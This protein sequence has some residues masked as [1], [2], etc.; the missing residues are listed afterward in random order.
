MADG[1]AGATAASDRQQAIQAL[2]AQLAALPKGTRPYDHARVAYRLGLAYAESP[3]GGP[4]DGLRK[5]LACFDVAAAIFDPRF[6]PIEHARVLNAAGACHRGLGDRGRAATLF[7]KAAELLENSDRDDERAA[8]LNNLGLARAEAGDPAGAVEAFDR[9]VELFDRQ[10]PEGRRGLAATL[11][12][13]GQARGLPG[14][15]E[16][17]QESLGDYQEALAVLGDEEA[18]Y[19]VGLVHHSIGVAYSSLAQARPAEREQALARAMAA[20]EES[21]IVF[22][23]T[24]FP[25]QHALAKH[26][27]GLARAALGGTDNL[28]RALAAFEDAVAILDPR[29]HA[30]PWKQAYASLERTEDHLATSFPGMGRS[31][32]FAALAAAGDEEERVRLVHERLRRLLA[33]PEPRRHAALV[34]LALA[35]ARLPRPSAVKLMTTELSVAMEFPLD[36]QEPVLQA[37]FDAHQQ[38][39]AEAR[40][41]ADRALDEAIGEAL[42]G[43]QRIFVRDFLTGR[44]WERP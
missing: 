12:N 43:P 25:F 39:D 3:L 28:R 23:R 17:V 5:A 30:D 1:P 27:L 6:D 22:T 31:A 18:P 32:H 40:E 35:G 9:A 38:L 15:V 16:A 29:L 20:F 26:N 42:Q 8:A 7:D 36:Q 4:A 13:R 44:G 34:D 2:E 37:R 10:S 41:E 21:L 14:T 33:L 11:H 19:H 24:A